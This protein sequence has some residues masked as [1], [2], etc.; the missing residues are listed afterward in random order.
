M[1]DNCLKCNDGQKRLVCCK[2][3]V[4]LKYDVHSGLLNIAYRCQPIHLPLVTLY[5]L[6]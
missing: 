6:K 3:K 4:I 2:Y 5:L 1:S